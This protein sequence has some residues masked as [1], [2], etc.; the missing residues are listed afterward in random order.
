MSARIK[1]AAAN[2]VREIAKELTAEKDS[3]P[4]SL[5]DRGPRRHRHG[6]EA[7]APE[8]HRGIGFQE[9]RLN[10]VLPMRHR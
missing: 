1:I 5:N 6:L 2:I 8:S 4:M 10:V 9:Y 7:V 3:K